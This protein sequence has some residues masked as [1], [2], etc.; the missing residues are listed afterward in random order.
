MHF[1]PDTEDEDSA[2]EKFWPEGYKQI[3]REDF[4]QLISDQL[5]GGQPL[6]HVY[7]RQYSEKYSD[8]G[9]FTSK[10]V[11]MIAIGAENGADDAFD[12]IISAFL[13]ESPL[14]EVHQYAHYFWPGVFPEPVKNKL[15]QIITDEYRQDGVYQHAYKVGYEGKYRDFDEYIQRV[16]EIVLTGAINGT[17]DMLEAIYRSYSPLYPLPPARRLPRRLKQW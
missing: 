16:A 10:I 14:P 11:D 2:A 6:K 12:E 3:I 1:M 7:Q 8:L 13:T 9:Q 4:R 17:D 15:R 5:D